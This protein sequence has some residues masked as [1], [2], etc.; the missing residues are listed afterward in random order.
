MKYIKIS[1]LLLMLSLI[2]AGCVSPRVANSPMYS[3]YSFNSDT[4]IHNYCTYNG[5]EYFY[6]DYADMRENKYGIYRT[7]NGKEPSLLTDVLHVMQMEANETYLY[8]LDASRRI[9][10]INLETGIEQSTVEDVMCYEF[11]V[12]G[13]AIFAYGEDKDRDNRFYKFS[14]EDIS[15]PPEDVMVSLQRDEAT[16]F[17]NEQI[18]IL[19]DE[20][21]T[22][23]YSNLFSGGMAGIWDKINNKQ[24]YRYSFDNWATLLYMEKRKALLAPRQ[25]G[26]ESLLS[27]YENGFYNEKFMEFPSGYRFTPNNILSKEDGFYALLHK[28]NGGRYWGY[29][30]P[31]IYHE[32]DEL[33][34]VNA[35]DGSYEILYEAQDKKE[36]IVGFWNEK[37]YLF[38]KS[39]FG[40]DIVY[41]LD[42]NSGEKKKL[43]E[44]EERCKNYTFELCGEKLFVWGGKNQNS[45]IFVGA[46]DL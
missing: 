28:G 6:Y 33:I 10:Q 17:N 4:I 8:Y 31:Q 5:E 41:T 2:M 1:F 44:I 3:V 22:Y 30:A 37:I 39:T 18:E 23:I 20:K 14:T 12:D 40:K 19:S 36:R 38:E 13:N 45:T 9:F 11:A 27:S 43:C 16:D 24:I 32:S 46:Y 25:E 35:D 21:Y 42:S 34:M 26:D 29:D 15:Q 7:K